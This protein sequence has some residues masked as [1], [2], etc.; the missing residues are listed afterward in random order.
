MPGD[1]MD[2]HQRHRQL[3][4]LR[5]LEAD[6]THPQPSLRS[7][8]RFPERQ[9]Q[10]QEQHAG[11]VQP[12]RPVDEPGR[13][14]LGDQEH[15]RESDCEPERLAQYEIGIAAA[16]AVER[17]E[18]EAR[19]HNNPE[20]QGQIQVQPLAQDVSGLH[21]CAQP[22]AAPGI[23]SGVDIACMSRHPPAADARL[24]ASAASNP[25]RVLDPR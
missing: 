15:D 21:R 8:R 22:D 14:D 25:A 16:S 13:C 2:D 11:H 6:G 12:G 1:S 7:L 17:D 5:G 23:A 18:S 20:Q 9:H 4:E 10:A 3:H 24:A 19:K